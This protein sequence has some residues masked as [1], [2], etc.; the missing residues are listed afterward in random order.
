MLNIVMSILRHIME[1]NINTHKEIY[2][3][4]MYRVCS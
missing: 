4:A 2:N 1:D 3:N